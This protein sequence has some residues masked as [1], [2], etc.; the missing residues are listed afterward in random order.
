[1]IEIVKQIINKEGT[2]E[3]DIKTTKEVIVQEEI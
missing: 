1:M 2:D 3:M